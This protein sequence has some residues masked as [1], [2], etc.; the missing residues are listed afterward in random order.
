MKPEAFML[1]SSFQPDFE[2]E[3]FDSG[4]E[5]RVIGTAVTGNAQCYPT[6]RMG[7]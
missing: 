7:I 4:R 1:A 6:G 5:Y 2:A 3:L